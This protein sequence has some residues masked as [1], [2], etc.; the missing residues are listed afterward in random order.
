L[1]NITNAS[2][3]IMIIDSIFIFI[4]YDTPSYTFHLL[5]YNSYCTFLTKIG[6]K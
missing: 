1:L 4:F 2:I 5:V 6:K 3:A